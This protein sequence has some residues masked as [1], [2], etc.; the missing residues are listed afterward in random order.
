MSLLRDTKVVV[1]VSAIPAAT[2]KHVTHLFPKGVHSVLA[3]DTVLAVH[4]HLVRD[5]SEQPGHPFR[6]VVVPDWCEQIRSERT[7]IV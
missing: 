6:G 5:L 3:R 2:S 1:P 7:H 4:D